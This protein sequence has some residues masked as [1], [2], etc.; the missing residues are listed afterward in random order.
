MASVAEQHQEEKAEEQQLPEGEIV[1]RAV[2]QDGD[3]ALAW[4]ADRLW[5]SGLAAGLSMGFSLAT[6]GLLR[7]HLPD[8]D[9]MPLISKFGYAVGFVI[10]VLGRQQLFTEQTLTA[11]LPLLSRDRPGVFIDV[12]RM[13]VVVLVANLVGTAGFAATA[14]W[15]EAFDPHVRTVF[16]EIGREAMSHSFGT[17]LVR[18]ILAGFLIAT[19]IWLLP[20]SG[21]ARL[22]VVLLL[23]YIVGLAGLSHIIAGS[24]ET[25]LLVFIGERAFTDYLLNYFT[26]TLTGNAIGGVGLVALLAHAQHAPEESR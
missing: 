6:E 17:T 16:A 23:T 19:M 14:A 22:F 5:W 8:A 25:L 1:Y 11:V 2:R 13:W 26:P 3:H 20:G 9:W 7:A 21:S 24:T 18:G 10:V 12:A 15:T 4:S